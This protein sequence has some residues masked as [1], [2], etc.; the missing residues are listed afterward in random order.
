MLLLGID[1]G[2]SS[3]KVSVV[4]TT[5]QQCL[6]HAQYPPTESKIISLQP[7]WAEQSPE[8]WWQHTCQAVTGLNRSGAFDPQ[9]I[10]AIGIA[11]QMH[12]LVLVDKEQQVLRDSIIWC[13][14]RAVPYGEKAWQHIGKHECLSSLLNS[15]GN[16]TAAK[17]A[18]VKDNEPEIFARIHK[19]M[20]PGDYIAMKLTG[21]ITTT[22]PA[23]SEGIFWD[24]Q[25]DQVSDEVMDFFGFSKRIIPDIKPVFSEHGRLS[26]ANG[27]ALGLKAGI[28]VSYKSGDQPNNALSLNVFNPGEIAATAGTSGV[29]Y[30]VS[31][32]LSADAQSRV[33][34]FAHVNY[35]PQAKRLGVLMNINGAGIMNNWVKEYIGSGLNYQQMNEEAAKVATGSNGLRIFPFGN[36]AERIFSNRIIGAQFHRLD[37]NQHSGAHIFRAVQEGIAFTFR[38]GLDIMRSNGINPRIIR[39]GNSNMFQSRLFGEAFV[40]STGVPVELY[41]NDGSVGAALGAGIGAQIFQSPQ[42]AF[43]KFEPLKII[44]PQQT[45]QYEAVYQDWKALLETQ[46]NN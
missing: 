34:T 39:A 5:T 12:G 35:S 43:R 8:M 33:N 27:Q 38:Y 17:L 6:A 14:S 46:L 18:W 3:V 10:G 36:G 9:D 31:E 21:E 37:L 28:P 16:F 20:L 45:D 24:F 2:T 32:E 44:E 42:E 1:V 41:Q 4:E 19:M 30:A 26:A 7:G 29:I 25:K 13:D 40:N 15:P 11:Y 23:L 22:V